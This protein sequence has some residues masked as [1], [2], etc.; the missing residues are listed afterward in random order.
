[1]IG[2]LVALLFAVALALAALKLAVAGGIL[3]AFALS[4]LVLA[5]L[6]QP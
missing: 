3:S 6:V 2:A 4:L 1:M 5:L